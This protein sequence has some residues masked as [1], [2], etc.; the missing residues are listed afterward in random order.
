LAPALLLATASAAIAQTPPVRS[1]APVNHRLIL[2]D[3]SYQLVRK[4]EIAGDRVRYLSAE[5]GGDWEELPAELVDWEATRKW[6]PGQ[7]SAATP[8]AAPEAEDEAVDEQAAQPEVA[9]GLALPD[10]DGVFALDTVQGK[11]V[12]VELASATLS[13]NGKRLMGLS[14]LNPLSGTKA[15][16]EL[17]GAHARLHLHVGDLVLYLALDATDDAADADEPASSAPP[18]NSGDAQAA[19]RKQVATGFALVRAD[20]RNEKRILGA[21]HLSLTG[22]ATQNENVI[23][24]RVQPLA[25]T[26]WLKITPIQPLA[27]GEYALVEILSAKQIGESVWEFRVDPQSGDN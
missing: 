25:G 6:E 11:P 13:V 19:R 23:P 14:A 18:A 4:Y 24:A 7:S 22:K 3:G 9:K 17:D 5:R 26:H 20:V 2:K 15:V 1:G 21:M 10:R 8:P 16:L 12:L 27:A